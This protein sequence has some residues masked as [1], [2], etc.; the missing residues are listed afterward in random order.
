MNARS[1]GRT[2]DIILW[3]PTQQYLLD[4]SLNPALAEAL[5]IAG[6][7]IQNVF[8]L[9]GVQPPTRILDEQ[10][11]PRC[12]EE[13][14]IWITADDAARKR[15]ARQLGDHDIRVLWVKRPGGRMGTPYQLA[16]LSQSLL[17]FDMHLATRRER[18]RHYEIGSTLGATPK[19]LDE[20][21]S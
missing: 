16:H 19:P 11:I 14:R 5:R 1:P 10:I 17:K 3:Q 8:E 15:H 12:R 20:R 6:W 9:F 7:P 13:N 21:R 18:H 2:D 4:E